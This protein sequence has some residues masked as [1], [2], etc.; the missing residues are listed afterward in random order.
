MTE[1]AH[2]TKAEGSGDKV[3]G[4]VKEAVGDATGDDKLKNQGKR[5]Q[6]EGSLKKA[7]GNVKNAL[8]GK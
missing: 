3:R 6:T 2:E 8:K 1:S 5:D 4:Q 7:W